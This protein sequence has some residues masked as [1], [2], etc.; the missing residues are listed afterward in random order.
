MYFGGSKQC[1]VRLHHDNH[2]FDTSTSEIQRY[3]IS[4]YGSR[5]FDFDF[6]RI[7][8]KQISLSTSCSLAPPS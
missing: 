3:R 4:F 5:D 8:R 7:A 6:A 2:L 1:H